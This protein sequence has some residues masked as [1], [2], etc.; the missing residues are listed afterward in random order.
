M[1]NG[2]HFIYSLGQVKSLSF[3]MIREKERKM[4]EEKK[5][6]FYESPFGASL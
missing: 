1:Q 2:A 6:R 5:N 4:E 3:Q